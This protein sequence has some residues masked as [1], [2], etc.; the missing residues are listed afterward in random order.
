MRRTLGVLG[1]MALAVAL[2][3]A[4]VQAGDLP[5]PAL[6]PGVA[7]P[8]TLDEVCNTRWG[9]DAR[10]VTASMKREVFKRYGLTGNDDPYCQPGGCEIDHIISRELAGADDIR[11]LFP[12]PYNPA[13]KW[14][15]R[16]KDRLENVLHKKVCAGEMTLEEAQTEIRTDWI[17]AYKRHIGER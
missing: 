13:V 9:K 3:G 15:A 2:S 14:N 10:A 12:M 7:R 4:P 16:V 17:A 8:L 1:A 11:N 5:N 6:S